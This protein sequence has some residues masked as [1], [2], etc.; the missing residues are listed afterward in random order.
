MNA[1]SISWEN[2]TPV[3]VTN[4]YGASFAREP[5]SLVASYLN[6]KRFELHLVC[7]G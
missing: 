3:P 4:E 1:C 7:I 5:G 6:G 2:S